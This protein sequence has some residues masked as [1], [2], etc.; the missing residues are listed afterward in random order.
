MALAVSIKILLFFK[1]A[2]IVATHLGYF[3][4]KL[5]HQELSK[6]IQSGHTGYEPLK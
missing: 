6:I 3:W 2:Q 5:W 1:I 4:K